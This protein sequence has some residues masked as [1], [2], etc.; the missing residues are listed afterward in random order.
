MAKVPQ[1]KLL[2]S[3]I[4][5]GMR[6]KLPLSWTNHPFLFNR[7]DI[8]SAAQIEMIRGL[9]VPYVFLLSELNR[10]SETVR[11]DKDVEYEIEVPPERDLKADTRKAIRLSQKRFLENVNN[12]R[13]VFGKIASDPEGAYRLSASLVEDLLSHLQEVEKPFLTLVGMD[14]NDVSVTQHG[15]S[16]AVLAMMMGHALDLSPRELRDIALGSLLH[17]IGKLKVPDVIRRKRGALT[18]HESNYLQMHPNFAYDMLNRSGLFPKEVLHIVLHHH[19]FIDGSGFPDGLTDHKIPIITQIVSLA[20]DY[21]QQLSG[22]QI[23]SPQVALGYLFKN[24]A[25][26]HAESLIAI[27]VKILGIYPPGTIVKLSDGC[28]A[29]VMMTTKDVSQPQVWACKEDGSEPS[30]RFLSNEG[31]TVQKAIKAE[32][33]S[34]G[35]IRTLQVDKGISFYFSSLQT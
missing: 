13:N 27:L 24:R 4:Q 21:D 33:L 10:G 28:I 34:E 12:C 14:D 1:K 30:L 6:V 29:K 16:V 9:G 2:L 19:E 31:V 20:N 23:S 7:V 11:E 26:K 3:E 8:S 17:D 32:E 5:L 35:A 18:P 15:V 25:T 22:Q